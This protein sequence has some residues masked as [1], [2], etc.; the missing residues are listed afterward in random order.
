MRS[1]V[2]T[3]TGSGSSRV[4]AY[5]RV[6]SISTADVWIVVDPTLLPGSDT[7]IL[8]MIATPGA[9]AQTDIYVTNTK[10][11]A[12][13]ATL[14]VV[15]VSER[16]RAVRAHSA[17]DPNPESSQTLSLGALGTKVTT[18]TPSN[19]YI[20]LTGDVGA[21]SASA[22]VTMTSSGTTFGSALP[23]LPASSA[24]GD[25]QLK[26]FSGVGDSSARTIAAKTPATFRSSLMLI[27]TAG[28]SAEVR[29]TVW[30]SLTGSRATSRTSSFRDFSLRPN[31][32]MV[33]S[34]LARKVIGGQRDAFG[35]LRDTQVDVQ[36]VGGS[37]RVLSYVTSIDNG[38]G[39]VV[40][41]D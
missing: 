28:Q 26:R 27:E 21:I 25:G 2:I 31:Q 24:L 22:R 41:R 12:V 7:M 9:A 32:M 23:V 30:Y 17:S 14:N 11:T 39:D 40:I 19:G 1:I 15:N 18:M 3:N 34:D 5:A 6:R 16:R 13:T 10:N 33:V 4:N 36:V 37:G 8:P 20:R 29:V 38:S 35:D